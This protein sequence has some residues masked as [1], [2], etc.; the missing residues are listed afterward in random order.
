M[1]LQEIIYALETEQD[2]ERYLALLTNKIDSCH[3][4]VLDLDARID[5]LKV[6]VDIYKSFMD[7]AKTDKERFV[8]YLAQCLEMSGKDTMKGELTQMKFRKPSTVVNITYP[9]EVPEEFRISKTTITFDKTAIKDYLKATGEVVEFAE[10]A[11][12][13][14]NIMFGRRK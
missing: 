5:A 6:K 2:T 11:D 1:T 13:N 7:S 14:K 8:D 4:Y 3:S 9:D 12:G 10:L